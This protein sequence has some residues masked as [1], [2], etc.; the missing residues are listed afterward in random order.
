MTT[1]DY[2]TAYEANKDKFELFFKE[3]AKTYWNIWKL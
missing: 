2:I 3:N 1:Q